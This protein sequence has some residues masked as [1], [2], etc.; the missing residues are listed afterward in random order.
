MTRKTGE[1]Q[2]AG[3]RSRIRREVL[4]EE[5]QEVQQTGLGGAIAPKM[6]PDR[7]RPTSFRVFI[8]GVCQR[9]EQT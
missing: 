8:E 6:V 7:N 4:A 9:V 1:G 2:G 3:K 5:D